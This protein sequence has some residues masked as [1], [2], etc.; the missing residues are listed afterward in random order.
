MKRYCL[1]VQYGEKR[2]KLQL[3]KVKLQNQKQLNLEAES[4]NLKQPS[5]TTKRSLS[6]HRNFSLMYF[7]PRSFNLKIRTPLNSFSTL[8]INQENFSYSTEPRKKASLLLNSTQL[9]ITSSIPLHSS[10]PSSAR[11]SLAT[12]P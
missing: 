1:I 12:L 6:E 8:S 5:T 11:P 4:N 3:I 9:A 7:L 2:R 10:K